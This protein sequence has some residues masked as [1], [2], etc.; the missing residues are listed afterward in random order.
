MNKKIKNRLAILKK[1]REKLRKQL[2][3]V[4][5]FTDDPAEPVELER[6]IA[7]IT[8]ELAKLAEG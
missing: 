5:R 1:R 2:S 4:R 6:Q 8:D 3:V 7:E